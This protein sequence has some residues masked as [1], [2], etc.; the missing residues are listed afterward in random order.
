VCQLDQTPKRI[1]L[2]AH[3]TRTPEDKRLLFPPPFLDS[4]N[5]MRIV[6][7]AVVRRQQK[8]SRDTA[9]WWTDMSL[10]A[11]FGPLQDLLGNFQSERSSPREQEFCVLEYD[12]RYGDHDRRR[13]E[14][15]ND[16]GRLV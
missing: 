13:H 16:C 14:G 2:L 5:L 7:A 12:Y 11:L 1:D 3:K 9:Q 15:Q 6:S 4:A 10:S 8:N